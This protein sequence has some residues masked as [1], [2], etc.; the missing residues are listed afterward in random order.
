MIIALPMGI[1]ATITRTIRLTTHSKRIQATVRRKLGDPARTSRADI[2]K[3]A[4][5]VSKLTMSNPTNI[6]VHGWADPEAYPIQK[7]GASFEF[8]RTI[9]HLRTRTNTFGAVAR[10]RNQVCRSIH[11]FFQEQGFLYIH[12][13]IITASDCEGAGEMF[14][15][16]TLDLANVAMEDSGDRVPGSGSGDREANSE[17]PNPKPPTRNPNFSTDFFH[18]P[19]Y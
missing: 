17:S 1:A 7:K 11:E 10:V 6:A 19:A 3:I 16:T 5:C 15:V 4:D 12:T 8:L 2:H 13:P 18:R 9:A 14:K